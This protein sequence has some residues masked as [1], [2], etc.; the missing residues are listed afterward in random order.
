L[1]YDPSGWLYLRGGGTTHI[2]DFTLH[3]HGGDFVM[4]CDGCGRGD[5]GRALVHDF[6]DTLVINYA[7]D[8][9]GG[10]RI[11]GPLIE[12][13]GALIADFLDAGDIDKQIRQVFC[14]ELVG[15]INWSN[16]L[17]CGGNQYY[18]M[19]SIYGYLKIPSSGTY[20][21]YITTDDGFI[22]HIDGSR[23][24][25]NWNPQPATEYSCSRWL[26]K[27][28]HKILI[29]HF[30]GGGDERLKFEWSGPGIS[31][32]L[33]PSSNLAYPPLYGWG[34]GAGIRGSD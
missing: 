20:T 1:E 28:W 31:R 3:H 21:F 27:G 16:K 7:K 12:G 23:C 25:G 26:S 30:Q 22:F 34:L 10:T 2:G 19:V 33:V 5:G 15:P 8:F 13:T 18:W 17:P 32:Q 29:Q 24:M 6:N 14:M 11:D 9:S 4:T